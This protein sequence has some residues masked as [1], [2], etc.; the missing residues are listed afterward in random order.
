MALFGIG[1]A[2]SISFF[3]I[4]LAFATL[5]L[6]FRTTATAYWWA[7]FLTII[8][9]WLD[10]LDGYLARKLGE[11]SRIGSVID[12]LSD[13]NVEQ[14]YWVT[15]AVLGWVPLWVPLVIITRGIWVDGLR[16][17]AFEQGFTAFGT[18]SMMKH[19]LGILLV[20]SRFS[21]WTYA[22]CK[23]AVFAFLILVHLPSK[24]GHYPFMDGIPYTNALM[25][26]TVFFCIVRGLPVLI[27]S[28]RFLTMPEKPTA[29]G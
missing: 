10:G 24:A 15:Y 18:T 29:E 2:N 5:A 4:G 25:W 13:R 27:E 3:R 11:T 6:L 21:R 22:V 19:P 20:S 26:I 14:L 17:L 23:A 28:K 1:V 16:A 9:I 7:F 8:V 12:I